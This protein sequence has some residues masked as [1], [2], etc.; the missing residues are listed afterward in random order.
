MLLCRKVG[1]RSQPHPTAQ[2]FHATKTHTGYSA[3]A[4]HSCC[5]GAEHGNEYDVRR[6]RLAPG[7]LRG[8]GSLSPQTCSVL[9]FELGQKETSVSPTPTPL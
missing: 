6:N 8:N 2:R 5:T 3:E 1:S 4:Q 7:S 9:I